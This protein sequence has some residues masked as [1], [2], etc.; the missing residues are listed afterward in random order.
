MKKRIWI[1]LVLAIL[2]VCLIGV[3]AGCN[4]DETP[5]E[6]TAPLAGKF[7]NDSGYWLNSDTYVIT[8]TLEYFSNGTA[9]MQISGILVSEGEP[10]NFTLNGT[11]SWKKGDNIVSCVWT[12]PTVVEYLYTGTEINTG[13]AVL[14]CVGW[15]SL[16]E[17][18]GIYN[19]VSYGTSGPG[20]IEG[21]VMQYITDG[22]SAQT[23]TA[24][25]SLGAEF[26]RWSDGVLT[27][28]RTDDSVSGNISVFAEFRR[29]TNVF[30][31][32]YSAGTGG[33][34]QGETTQEVLVNG[35]GT[36]V[37]AVPDE[38]YGFIKWS[39]GVTTATR[40]DTNITQHLSV[41]AEFGRKITL[42]YSAGEG[43]TVQGETTQELIEGTAGTSVT[44]VPNEGWYFVSW[45]DGVDT[46]TRIDTP[47]YHGNS[48]VSFRATFAPYH[49]VKYIVYGEG[50]TIQGDTTQLVKPEETPTAV[51]AVPDEGYKL[52]GWYEDSV[53]DGNLL[54]AAGE[55]F[56]GGPIW[57]YGDGT[58]T[59][60]VAFEPIEYICIYYADTGGTVNGSVYRCD[61]IATVLTGYATAEIFAV[62]ESGY[63]FTGWSDGRTDNPRVDIIDPDNPQPVTVT[64]R[65]AR[66]YTLTYTAGAGGTITGASIQGVP[67]GED[68]TEVTAVPNAGCSFVRWSDGVMTATRKDTNVTSDLSVTAEFSRGSFTLSYVAG[69]GGT[70]EGTTEQS[71]LAGDSGTAVTAVPNEGYAFVRWSDGVTTATR[72]DTDVA[73]NISVTAEFASLCHLTYVA[74]DGGTIEGETVQSVPVG[75]SGTA[76]TAVPNEGYTFVRWSDGV[77]TATR[78]DTDINS[79]INVTAEFDI[80]ANTVDFAGGNGTVEH[81]YQIANSEHLRN[82][83]LYPSAYFVLTADIVLPE[84]SAGN[85]NF[86]PLFSDEKPFLG[87]LDGAGHKITNL[88][89]Y[90]TETFYSGLFSVIGSTGSVKN[91]TLE[92]ALMSGTNYV[93]IVAGWSLGSITDCTVS[94]AVTH[95]VANGYKVFVGG[96]SGR[97]EGNID[98]CSAAVNLTVTEAQVEVYVGGIV[99]YLSVVG[100]SSSP[101]TLTASGTISVSSVHEVYVGGLGG[102]ASS[103]AYLRKCHTEMQ[104]SVTGTYAYVGGLV[105]RANVIQPTITDSYAIGNVTVSGDYAYAG[106]LVG[107]SMRDTTISDSYATGNVTAS[108][109]YSACAGGLLGRDGDNTT[110]I[111]NSYATGN[112]T[113]SSSRET[114]AGGLVGSSSIG[115]LTITD[116]YATGDVTAS[117]SSNTYAGGLIGYSSITT[118]RN[119]Y[120][121]SA[122]SAEGG[123][124]RVGGLAGYVSNS[125]N[126]ENAH[127]LKSAETDAIYAVGYSNS[128]GVP[129][130]IGSTS[131][132]ILDEFYTLADTLNAGREVPVWEH[133]GENTLPSLIT[134]DDESA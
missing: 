58:T 82:V 44:A 89:V 94:G 28:T 68:G 95:I 87:T 110:T 32:Y 107:Y 18:E 93:G 55:T 10:C 91:L 29:V 2:F 16:G 59:Y 96:V 106:G 63:V 42:S 72:T 62:P 112:V 13:Y 41:T 30:S 77:T 101:L 80:I 27:P 103:S 116:S 45:I 1:C 71:V 3:L 40:T 65:F 31:L 56:S 117:G 75:G 35:S 109:S 60:Y 12:E 133:T 108:G 132:A 37:T 81:P 128:L 74:G 39:D 86:T 97:A 129:T 51:T 115:T 104:I 64:A 46:P 48:T 79:D 126:L 15:N 131:H 119:A 14:R 102:H 36:E 76:V 69:E 21:E 22:E 54:I 88:T 124:V 134:G 43:G 19:L 53:S 11:Y 125:V 123:T 33:T 52:K 4:P 23:V 130:S 99:G 111:T 7:I 113:A 34:I 38:G 26:V 50:G 105:G 61:S 73:G 120:S 98:G 17:F 57:Y 118:V 122:V 24:V 100:S 90:N 114:Y 66:G 92:N 121:S 6:T 83:E 47:S 5:E 67:T 127:W 85:N 20:N 8:H 9:Q 78:T 25:P 84:V 49:T 70:I